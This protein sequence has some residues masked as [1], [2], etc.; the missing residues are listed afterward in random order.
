MNLHLE[1]H[2]EIAPA[3]TFLFQ[4]SLSLGQTPIDWKH[5]YVCPIFKKGARHEPANYRPVLL[6]CILCKLME[7]IIVSNVIKH[8]ENN[9]VLT[10]FQHGFR[11]KRSCE[12]Q[13]IGLIQDLTL[14]MDRKMQTDMIVLDFA[15]AFDK[16]S[17]HAY[18]TS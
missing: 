7:H 3:V 1:R 6:I 17:H 11:S 2:E 14:T 5:A 4:K 16:V 18:Y 15:K 10:K 8:I 13:L 9:K 12:A